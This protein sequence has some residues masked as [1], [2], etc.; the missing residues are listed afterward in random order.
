[1]PLNGAGVADRREGTEGDRRPCWSTKD[2]GLSS[3]QQEAM[4]SFKLWSEV[5]WVACGK[6]PLAAVCRMCCGSRGENQTCRELAG[7]PGPEARRQEIVDAQ[8]KQV[9]ERG[10]F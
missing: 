1:M 9:G 3:E 2:F 7:G 5:L 10:W 8:T 4:A 6:F